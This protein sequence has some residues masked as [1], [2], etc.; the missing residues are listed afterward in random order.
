MLDSLTG[1]RESSCLYLFRG[2]GRELTPAEALQLHVAFKCMQPKVQLV[3]QDTE[4]ESHD[5]PDAAFEARN[6]CSC[7]R[8][9]DLNA[10]EPA[11]AR[12]V[13]AVLDL[14]P[15]FLST[16]KMIAFASI[17]HERLGVHCSGTTPLRLLAT[18]PVCR[19]LSDVLRVQGLGFLC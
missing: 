9:Q 4:E 8:E 7:C 19:C 12:A 6:Q 15:Y 14:N 10:A 17:T 11:F 2:Q 13:C 3:E 1:I 18:L 5:L 16:S